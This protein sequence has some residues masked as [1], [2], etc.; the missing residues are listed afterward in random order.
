MHWPEPVLFNDIAEDRGPVLVTVEYWIAAKDREP[1]LAALGP[2][3]A[4]RWH[5]GAYQW[6]VF[7]DTAEEGR[8]IETFMVD[9]WLE[10]L[11]QHERVSIADRVHEAALRRFHTGGSP[12]ITHHIAP[13]KTMVS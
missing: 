7:E 11:L 8:W 10:H 4:E 2:V 12:K 13:G 3:A 1:F 6:G 5:D 9:S